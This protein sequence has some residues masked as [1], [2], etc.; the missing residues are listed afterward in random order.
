MKSVKSKNHSL[1]VVRMYFHTSNRAM[2]LIVVYEVSRTVKN[3]LAKCGS[4][5]HARS[6]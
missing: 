1:P 5:I 6:L 2:D 3:V 4:I